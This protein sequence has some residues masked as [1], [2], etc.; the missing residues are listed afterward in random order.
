MHLEFQRVDWIAIF[1]PIFFDG[2]SNIGYFKMIPQKIIIFDR[3]Y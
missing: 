3:L 2:I 1:L